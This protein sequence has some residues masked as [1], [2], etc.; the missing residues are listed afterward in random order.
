MKKK[1][2]RKDLEQDALVYSTHPEVAFGKTMEEHLQAERETTLPPSRQLL[3]VELDRKG[4]KGKTVTRI[5][6]Y[7]GPETALQ[8]LGKWL[9]SQCG[10]GGSTKDGQ[11][12]IQGDQR[13]KVVRLLTTR[14]YQVKRKGG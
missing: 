12:L 1:K 10:V 13:E 9:K 6:G 7:V 14:G 4:R 11:I 2:R 3:Y 5:S 8:E